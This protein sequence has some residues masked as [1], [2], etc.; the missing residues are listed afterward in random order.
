MEICTTLH[1]TF[2]MLNTFPRSIGLIVPAAYSFGAVDLAFVE[3][4]HTHY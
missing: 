4:L 3:L 2:S 1:H